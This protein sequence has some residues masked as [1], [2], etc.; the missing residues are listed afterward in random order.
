MHIKYKCPPTLYALA[1]QYASLS[2]FLLQVK[3]H[4]LPNHPNEK[5]LILLALPLDI[6]SVCYPAFISTLFALILWLGDCTR[7]WI[8][9][10]DFRLALCKSDLSS[11][12]LCSSPPSTEGT[13]TAHPLPCQTIQC[14]PLWSLSNL[15]WYLQLSIFKP[16]PSAVIVLFL[17]YVLMH[18]TTS[19]P[20]ALCISLHPH[21]SWSPCMGVIFL[22]F[23]WLASQGLLC[24]ISTVCCKF[25][26]IPRHKECVWID[27]VPCD[28]W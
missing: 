3:H 24:S 15:P 11:T 26:L 27:L 8:R 1:L 21:L 16:S 28:R 6:L 17:F 18:Q 9:Q 7:F 14:L 2:P 12:P 22:F 4:P 5:S 19:T 23:S 25:I 13:E 10:H 20:Q